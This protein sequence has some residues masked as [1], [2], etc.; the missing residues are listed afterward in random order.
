MKLDNNRMQKFNIFNG[1][2]HD[3]TKLFLDKMKSK[4]YKKNDLIMKEGDT[5]H[6]LL[7]L[8]D[9]QI[10]ITKALT[11]ST[12]KNDNDND[13]REKEFIRSKSEHNIIIGEISLFSK[14]SKRTA[15][16]K[17]L[18][19]CNIAYLEKKDFF[20]I[21]DKN[22][23]VGYKTINNLTQIITQR[24][25]DTNHQVLKLTTAFSLIMDS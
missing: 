20:E 22:P 5:G 15:T 12:N 13:N 21:C 8:L 10:N 18:T 24:L 2:N 9:G 1:L 23:S 4:S 6:S 19:N 17:A 3:E 14:D 11:L 7:F 16:V 25:I